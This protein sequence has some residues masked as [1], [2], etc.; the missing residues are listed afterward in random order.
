MM[1]LLQGRQVTILACVAGANVE[2]PSILK[3]ICTSSIVDIL[4][5]KEQRYKETVQRIKK[6]RKKK[7]N[8]EKRKKKKRLAPLAKPVF[9]PTAP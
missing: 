7:R 1:A 4:S 2:G 9:P 3:T 8:K 6:R 5:F